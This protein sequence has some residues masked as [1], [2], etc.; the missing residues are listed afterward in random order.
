MHDDKPEHECIRISPLDTSLQVPLITTPQMDKPEEPP[1]MPLTDTPR[2]APNFQVV[3]D[4]HRPIVSD[5]THAPPISFDDH[6]TCLVSIPRRFISPADDFSNNREHQQRID[7]GGSK[8]EPPGRCKAPEHVG[9]GMPI[10]DLFHLPPTHPTT[11][12]YV[13][14]TGQL[15][16]DH[17]TRGWVAVTLFS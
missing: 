9:P 17:S 14:T 16:H 8:F 2:A 6:F 7:P 10:I 15:A 12:R 5:L 1:P 13:D 11:S 4:H 3:Q